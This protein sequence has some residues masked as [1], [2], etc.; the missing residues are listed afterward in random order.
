MDRSDRM[1][2]EDIFEGVLEYVKA[3][4]S[5][6]NETEVL[7]KKSTLEALVGEKLE[8]QDVFNRNKELTDKYKHLA[9]SYGFSDFYSLYLFA[10]SNE[11]EQVSKAG[12]KDFSR[13]HK[14]RRTVIRNGKPMQTTIYSDPG[15]DKD[16]SDGSKP[17]PTG[18]S[19]EVEQG[20][21]A[22]DL[23]P[24]KIDEKVSGKTFANFQKKTS[25]LKLKGG[26]KL[27]S[28]MYSS[29]TGAFGLE[30]E[31]GE[32][33]VFGGFEENERYV[34]I[35]F[36][37]D[38]GNVRNVGLY[39]FYELVKFAKTRNKGVLVKDTD[40]PLALNLY[41]FFNLKKRRDGLWGVTRFELNKVMGDLPWL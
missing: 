40:N 34:Y 38:N 9:V 21:E 35:S 22:K 15:E 24:M 10:E 3:S 23:K 12:K 8:H 4:S 37:V 33:S 7:L 39:A 1:N 30:D 31:L 29:L 26:G 11:M 28:G 27:T 5:Q 32:P 19:E 2:P 36:I 18:E 25:K 6:A 14:V 17:Q 41:S 20:V 16:D 13:L